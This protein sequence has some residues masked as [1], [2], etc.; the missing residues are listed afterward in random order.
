MKD[1][2]KEFF[3]FERYVT[4]TVMPVV[5]WIG[6]A[7]AVVMGILNLVDGA[8]FGNARLIIHGVI[9]LFAGPVFVRVLCE[10]VMTFFKEE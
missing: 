5:F 1:W 2:W 8:R 7:I 4:P 10:W 9:V 6:V 3:T